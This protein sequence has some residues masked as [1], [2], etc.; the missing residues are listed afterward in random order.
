MTTE[1]TEAAT[2]TTHQTVAQ[3][4]LPAQEDGESTKDYLRRLRDENQKHRLRAE[5]FEKQLKDAQAKLQEADKTTQSEIEKVKAEARN[6]LAITKIEA[7][8]AKEGVLDAD[9]L[10]KLLDPAKFVFDENGKITNAAELVT[11]LKS[12]KPYLFGSI[13]TA[14]TA[15]APVATETGPRKVSQ[16]SKEEKAAHFKKLGLT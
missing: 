14:S 2:E 4:Q 10:E 8:A 16:M 9:V 15:K 1:N 13:S 5:D 3:V 11:T 12:E 6:Q 7:V